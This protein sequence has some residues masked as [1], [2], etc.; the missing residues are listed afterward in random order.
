MRRA[1]LD[2]GS[3]SVLLVVAELTDNGSEVLHETSAVTGLGTGVK[4]SGLIGLEYQDATLDAVKKAFTVSTELGATCFAYGTMALRI[5]KNADN[6]LSAAYLQGTPIKVITGEQEAQLGVEAVFADPMFSQHETMSVID[7][8]GH[9]T[10]VTTASRTANGL[11]I[12]HSKSVPIGALGLIE[13]DLQSES[14][15]AQ[16]QFAATIAIDHAIGDEVGVAPS[17]IAISLGATPANLV[18]IRD[19]LAIW[20]VANV[21]GKFLSFE[22]VGKAVGWLCAMSLLQRVE[23]VGVE[24]GREK[25]LHA[26]ALILERCMNALHVDACRVSCRGWRFALLNHEI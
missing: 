2:V 6:F 19:Q 18:S 16:E 15:D 7:P 12:M 25:T 22:E 4:N 8:G 13:T 5:A 1:I 20:N 10:E 24:N 3:N 17:G 21:H 14:P 26:G 23:L 9:S 11:N